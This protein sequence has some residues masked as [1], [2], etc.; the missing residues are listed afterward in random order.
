M[1][2]DVTFLSQGLLCA[3]WLYIPDDLPNTQQAPA[4]VMAISLTAVKELYSM[5]YAERFVAAGFVT[6]VFDYR[7][8]GASEGLPRGHLLP[9]EQHE[10][11]R[12]AI[13]WLARQPEVIAS[14]IGAWGLE[15]GAGHVVHLA[16]HDRRIKATV[17]TAPL[18]STYEAM[19]GLVGLT[20]VE[21]LLAF[22]TQDRIAR[23]TTGVVSYMQIVSADAEPA[24]LLGAEAFDFYMQ[25]ASLAPTWRNQITLEAVEKLLEYNPA[26]AIR[27]LA[28]TPL[29]MIAAEQDA[30]FP[31]DLVR[32]AYDQAAQPKRLAVLPCD[33]QALYQSQQWTVQAANLAIEWFHQH[34]RPSLHPSNQSHS[35]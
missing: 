32:A 9:H 29:L 33:H 31:I 15:Y 23:Y 21:Q 19:I 25:A 11:I 7:R 27:Y 10:D 12:N 5:S 30:L 28:P 16:V 14:R 22:I 26:A 35:L 13:T 6:L 17:A 2:R 34:L 24:L 3:G 8:S 4:I 18:L 1:R 20:G